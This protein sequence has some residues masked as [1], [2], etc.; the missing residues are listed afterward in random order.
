MKIDKDT[1]V[2]ALKYPFL[3]LTSIRFYF[4]VLFKLKGTGILCALQVGIQAFFQLFIHAELNMFFL[5]KA[6]F[7]LIKIFLLQEHK[8]NA[9]FTGFL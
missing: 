2:K 8:T 7:R 5:M 6:L 4:D 3:A 1:I 9:F